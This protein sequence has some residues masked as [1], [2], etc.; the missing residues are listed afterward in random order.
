MRAPEFLNIIDM[1]GNYCKWFFINMK[2]KVKDDD[3]EKNVTIDLKISSCIY[4]LER[5]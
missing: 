1:V 5:M 2:D 4:F 3:L